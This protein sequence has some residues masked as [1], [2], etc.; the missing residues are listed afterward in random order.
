MLFG[1]HEVVALA[2]QT[3]VVDRRVC[4]RE[5][6]RDHGRTRG[7]ASSRRTAHSH[8]PGAASLVALPDR[9][10]D[11]VRNVAIVFAGPFPGRARSLGQCLRLRSRSRTSLNTSRTTWSNPPSGNW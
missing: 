3:D 7:G 6:L 4:L 2:E 5:R 10:L 1:L 9:T 8:W 11:R